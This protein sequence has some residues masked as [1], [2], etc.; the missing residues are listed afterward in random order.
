L[1]GELGREGRGAIREAAFISKTS[2]KK[3]RQGVVDTTRILRVVAGKSRRGR[4]GGSAGSDDREETTDQALRTK[5]LGPQGRNKG[6]RR[7]AITENG[8]GGKGGE[9]RETVRSPPQDGEESITWGRHGQ[10]V[11]KKFRGKVVGMATARGLSATRDSVSMNQKTRKVHPC[12]NIWKEVVK[13]MGQA[14]VGKNRK[15]S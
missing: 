4:S 2:G 3:S 8:G 6:A 10:Y 14:D 13:G 9:P 7:P 1:G 12:F 15:Q 5:Q 11:R